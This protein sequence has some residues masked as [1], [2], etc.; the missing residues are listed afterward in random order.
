MPLSGGHVLDAPKAKIIIGWDKEKL[1]CHYAL[2]TIRQGTGFQ[3]IF[4]SNMR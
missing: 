2:M 3:N 4:I 1:H